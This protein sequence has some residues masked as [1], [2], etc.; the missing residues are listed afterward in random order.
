MKKTGRND[1]CPCGSGKKYKKCHMGREDELALKGIDEF[2]KEMS[3]RI[4]NLPEVSYGRSREILD[5]LDIPDLTGNSMG[6]KFVDLKAYSALN[7]F[8]GTHPKASKGMSGGV[9]I[10]IYRTIKSD[11]DN[12][13]LAISRDIDDSS[14]VHELAHALDYLSGSGL[15]PGT[16]EPLSLE[17]GVPVEHFEHPEEYG[18]WLDYLTKRFGILLDADDRII[19]YL[20]EKGMLIK[21]ETIRSGNGPALKLKSE[22]LFRFLSEKSKEIDRL[23]SNLEGYIGSREMDKD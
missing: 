3:S 18:Y 10:N 2:T 7:L 20:Y 9:F 13:Y 15:I 16:Q 14:L 5:D 12:V 19:A 11:P 23:I 6:I 17:T 22:Q 8:G 21:G 4:T 1:P